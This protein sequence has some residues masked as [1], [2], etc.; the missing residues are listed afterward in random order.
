MV[1]FKCFILLIIIQFVN[2][3]VRV[4]M[5]SGSSCSCRHS[6]Q[7]EKDNAVKNYNKI[8]DDMNKL[9]EII[10]TNNCK[11]GEEFDNI[12]S[13]NYN[14]ITCI[15]CSENYYRNKNDGSCKKCPPGFSS[16][17]GSKQC[18][19]CR[20]GFNDKCKNLK[21]SEEYCDIGSIISENG[22]IKCDNTKKY[23]MPKKN[24]EDKCLVCNDGHIV[25]NN[26]CIACPEGTYEKNNKCI[27]CEEQ[28]YNDLKGQNK[29]KKCNNQKSLTFSTKGGTHCENSIYYNLLDEF[30]SIVES[31][32]NIININNI[33]N[34]MIN[35]LQVSSIFYLNNKDV[36]TEFSAISVSLMA[37]FYMFS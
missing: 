1:S 28:T 33:L 20:N 25:K 15:K 29:C 11:L 22:C 13:I 27:L 8:F 14:N 19:K 5:S 21:K 10:T 31:N 36:I 4:R 2:A 6:I 16:E 30:N 9:N 32:T 12:E 24:Q 37:C 17:N 23:Y 3:K 26:K 7:K 34:P 35:V 18:T